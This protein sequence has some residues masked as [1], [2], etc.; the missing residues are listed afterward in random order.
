MKQKTIK[1]FNGLQLLKNSFEAEGSMEIA[2]NVVIIQDDIIQSRRGREYFQRFAS[3]QELNN[4][5]IYQNT[6][7]AISQNALYR[8]YENAS[9]TMTTLSGSPNLTINLTDHQILA[10]DYV[11]GIT[12][13]SLLLASL[14]IDR[15]KAFG[16]FRIASNINPNDFRI[17]ADE[18]ASATLATQPMTM[19]YYRRFSGET[20]SVLSSGVAV[21]RSTRANKNLYFTTDNGVLKLE[22]VDQPII[23]AGVSAATDLSGSLVNTSPA[24]TGFFKPDA[25]V[26]YRVTFARRDANENLVE[27]APSPQAVFIN[28]ATTTTTTAY[29]APTLTVTSVA[30][31]L[32]TND[33]IYI[34]S[35]VGGGTENLIGF[36]FAVTVTGV[37][38]F[39]INVSGFGVTAA[40]TSFTYGVQKN[41]RLTFSVPFGLSTEYVINIYRSTFSASQS[42]APQSDFRLVD[43]VSLTSAQV[44]SGIGEYT[45]SVPQEVITS[46]AVLYTNP[47]QDGPNQGNFPP[48]FCLDLGSWK[49]MT[50]YS[51]TKLAQSL[52]INL[53][54]PTL[55]TSSTDLTIAGEVYRFQLTQWGNREETVAA[56]YA[57]LT[58]TVTRNNHG[59]ATGDRIYVFATT[60]FTSNNDLGFK[61]ITVT[62]V[63][64]FTYAT[65]DTGGPGTIRAIG[66]ERVSGQYYVSIEPVTSGISGT[67]LSE[68]I[69]QTTRFLCQAININPGSPVTAVYL[70]DPDSAPGKIRLQAKSV[71]TTSF[72]LTMN[73]ANAA[74]LPEIPTSGTGLS[75]KQQVDPAALYVSKLGQPEAVPL[76]NRYI[77]GE[78]DKQILRIAPLRDSVIIIKEDGVFRVNGDNPGN[79]SIIPLDTTVFCKA[80][81]SVRTLNNSVY[82]LSNQGFVQVTDTS[83]RIASR[84]IEPVIT[85][86]FNRDLESVTGA[87]SSETD[88]M[89]MC[90][91]VL[92]NSPVLTGNVTRVYNYLTDTWTD[93][94]Q[95]PALLYNGEIDVTDKV[96]AIPFADRDYL[97]R[98][99]KD[100][101]R[102]DYVE[103]SESIFAKQGVWGE[104][105]A[106]LGDSFVTFTL[107]FT[108]NVVAGDTVTISRV[109]AGLLGA[110]ASPSD[111]EGIRTVLSVDHFEVVVST[112]AVT[113]TSSGLAIVSDGVREYE[114]TCD[115]TNGQVTVLVTTTEPHGFVPGDVVSV[116]YVSANIAA[117]FTSSSLITGARAV[118]SSTTFTFE[119]EASG[120]ASAT[121]TGS[122]TFSQNRK[123]EY[124]ALVTSTTPRLGD[125]VFSGTRVFQPILELKATS[126]LLTYNV[127]VG[128]PYRASSFEQNELGT[129]IRNRI[130]FSP[131]NTENMGL[132]KQNP[133]FQSSF[134]NSISCSQMTV[135][136]STDSQVNTV[137]TL[138]DNLKDGQPVSYGGWGQL[139]WGEFSWGAE[140]GVNREFLTRPSVILRTYVPKEAMLG[141]FIQVTLDHRR[142][143]ESIDLQSISNFNEAQTPRTS[144]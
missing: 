45:D 33:I 25:Q 29:G 120:I 122:V 39:T 24:G 87:V 7:L 93:F 92:P 34:N 63:N 20:V 86:T 96:V 94:N 74:F 132:L 2:E 106:T 136:F 100:Q 70:F 119:F 95:E 19:D 113:T 140:T 44:T 133:E 15:Q 78:A 71:A 59:F 90:T 104:G 56:T 32:A 142:A 53:I 75:S 72:A 127:R 12:T 124:L 141:T 83:V 8:I 107:P 41:V 5:F 62:G 48:P 77:V 31:G 3:G 64:T 49:T 121:V 81:D 61:T 101:N 65:T 128:L 98:E 43:E 123:Q 21:S 137:P 112:G 4:V 1:K 105:V 82:F 111:I 84:D 138:W 91:T 76:L 80:T 109:S 144:R 27:G 47:G 143:G 134:R 103:E 10:N 117:A 36:T 54:A 11:G 30:H 9:A 85:A 125:A 99:R 102:I 55:L 37:D 67:T 14:F 28:Q 16:G 57:A 68:S 139:E 13:S 129:F 40:A 73:T 22:S 108:P 130:K 42:A 69:D 126:S 6:T 97:V 135:T 18:N 17:V 35:S 66:V 89:Y 38:T 116:E 114:A 23:R 51:N 88:R 50:F 118:V 115:V 52:E 46:N 58:M 110:F 131:L 60:G 79:I 26:A